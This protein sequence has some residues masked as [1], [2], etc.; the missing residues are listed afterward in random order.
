MTD[1]GEPR[2]R[3]AGRT[4]ARILDAAQ[5]AFAEIGY[6]QTGIR[7]IAARAGVSSSLLN[8]YFGSKAGLFEAALLDALREPIPFGENREH[9]GKSLARILAGADLDFRLPAMI[10]L[11]IGDAEARVITA[12][13]ANERI[14]K[15]LAA[16]LGPPNAE[17]R[18]LDL[19]MV[20]TGFVVYT[21]QI[22]LRSGRRTV[23]SHSESWL[24]R[25][26]QAIIDESASRSRGK[27]AVPGRRK[28]SR[29]RQQR[30][31]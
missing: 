13:I 9:F 16:W 17:A 28:R 29:L 18:A 8:R 30:G 11:S 15:P 27:R 5:R 2:K 1:R 12:R 3:N 21:R 20:C 14:V 22:P 10:I 23:G 24:A 4:R 7:E 25:T 26:I 31:Q 6:A 19:I